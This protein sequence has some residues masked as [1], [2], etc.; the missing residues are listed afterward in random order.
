[1]KR[2]LFLDR[3]GVVNLET[4]Y[5]HRVE[6][7]IFIDGIF[8]L[9]RKF[10]SKGYLLFIITNQAG[11]ARGLYTEEQFQN[12]TS[13]MLHEFKSKGIEITRVY[14]CP[15]HPDFTGV[16]ECRKPAPGMILEAQKKYD[17]D[18]TKSIL[19]GDKISDIESGERAG[20]AVNVLLSDVPEVLETFMT[21]L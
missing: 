2:A 21:L 5:V 1:M 20:V 17:I 15:H 9:C 8:D 19:I 4:N 12:I 13:W 6:D 18:L 3:D 7:F 16:C 10:H 14:H 11:I